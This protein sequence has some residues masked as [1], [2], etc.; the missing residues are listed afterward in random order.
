M[1]EVRRLIMRCVTYLPS[2]QSCGDTDDACLCSNLTVTAIQDCE[3]CMFSAVIARNI[4]MPDP[5]A[6][7]KPGLTGKL[8]NKY[9]V[10]TRLTCLS[11]YI[12]ACQA[13]PVNISIPATVATLLLPKNWDGPQ[14]LHLSPAVTGL[15][16]I[17]GTVLGGGAL[18]ILSN[19]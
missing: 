17:I 10:Y 7:S 1:V 6:G 12:A 8:C 4:P 15:A 5:R 18:F 13:P 14:S 11:A 2:L 19:M 3:Q 9:I 16:L